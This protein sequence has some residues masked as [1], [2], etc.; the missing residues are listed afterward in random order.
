MMIEI[1]QSRNFINRRPLN[2]NCILVN[3]EI[4]IIEGYN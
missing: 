4:Y 1:S 3:L 2:A